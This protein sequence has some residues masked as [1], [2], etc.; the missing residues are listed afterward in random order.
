MWY[1]DIR[2]ILFVLNQLNYC[3]LR[4]VICR[5]SFSLF[6]P[7]FGGFVFLGARWGVRVGVEVTEDNFCNEALGV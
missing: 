5:V 6:Q 3:L 7:F 2:V 4:K 1:Y